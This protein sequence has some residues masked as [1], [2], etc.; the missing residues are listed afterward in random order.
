MLLITRLY[1]RFWKRRHRSS[2]LSKA[3]PDIPYVATSE[4]PMISP[5]TSYRLDNRNYAGGAKESDE[6]KI[7]LPRGK[8]TAK[9][10]QRRERGQLPHP[11]VHPGCFHLA[12]DVATLGVVT[13][14]AST[15]ETQRNKK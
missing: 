8:T 10:S 3:G 5:Q 12:L 15:H 6:Q 13:Q 2:A 11:W 4:R 1:I 9:R 14:T 7:T